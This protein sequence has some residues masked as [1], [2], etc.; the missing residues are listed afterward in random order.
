ME[1]Q[2]L[3]NNFRENNGGQF[4][5]SDKGLRVL[6]LQGKTFNIDKPI[7]I[8]KIN[9]VIF[10]NFRIHVSEKFYKNSIDSQE[11]DKE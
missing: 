3:I 8:H 2:D 9:N 5:P 11:I 7:Y 1:I 4:T 6:D 10:S